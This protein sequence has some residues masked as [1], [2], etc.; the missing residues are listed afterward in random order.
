MNEKP[1][2]A[3]L[4]NNDDDVFCFRLEL[5]KA[6]LERGYRLFISCPDGPK[7]DAMEK[8]YGL[9]KGR[10]F[11]Y[12]DPEIDRRGTSVVKDY[13]LLRHY[14]RKFKELRPD[15]ILTYTAKPNVYASIAARRLKIPVINNVTGFGSVLKQPGIKQK[16]IM[17][18]F[19]TAF[20]SS[21]SVMFQNETNLKLAKETK[22]VG[23]RCRLVPG[24]GV[25]LERFTAREYPDGGDGTGGGTV[26]FNYIGRVM[27]EKGVD[28]YLEAA[29]RIK[30]KYPDT[31]F[32]VLGFIE[33]TEIEYKEKLSALGESK[34]VIYRGSV[35]DV[36]P[37]IERAH[38]IIHPSVYGEGTSNVLLENAATA[39]PSITTDNPGCRETVRDG[40]T[41]FIYKG[42]DV[43]ALEE[44][45]VRFL[46][47]KNGERRE[48]GLL[49]RKYI[50][51]NFS[52]EIVIREYLNEIDRLTSGG[53]ARTEQN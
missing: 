10:D 45:I 46:G 17:R 19:R 35:E 24:S 18:L 26:V 16:F 2:I 41:G 48:M 29:S 23:G 51:E 33:P 47:M 50:E 1:L 13:R 21:A 15:V 4:T 39:R 34:T 43:D 28:D 36:R 5:V 25:A 14:R 3:L 27:R 9:K 8:E 53:K 20:K 38:C 11:I 32:N 31:E 52:R 12:D 37:W 30:A 42:G 22:L 44:L 49:G 40:I 6:I 7:F